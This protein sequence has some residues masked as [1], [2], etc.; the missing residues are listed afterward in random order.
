MN[1]RQWSSNRQGFLE[2]IADSDK[3]R[4]PTQKLLRL[5]WDSQKDTLSLQIQSSNPAPLLTKANVLKTFSKV[6]DPNGFFN[7]F[8]IRF[9]LLFQIIWLQMYDRDES[10]QDKS[11]LGQWQKLCEELNIVAAREIP[12]FIG[13]PTDGLYTQLLC[14]TDASSYAYGVAI[15]IRFLD[16]GN[17]TT[18]ILFSKVKV[19]PKSITPRSNKSRDSISIPRLELLAILIGVRAISFVEKQ[20]HLPLSKTILWSDS[21]I[22]L[23]WIN[24]SKLLKAFVRNRVQ[25]IKEKTPHVEFRYINT[26]DNPADKLTRGEEA[27]SIINDR[28]WWNGP[29]WLQDSQES[30]PTRNFPSFSTETEEAIKKEIVTKPLIQ[31]QATDT[32]ESSPYGDGLQAT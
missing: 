10:I 29:V 24:S 21:I 27:K 6:F 17:W 7:L 1:L 32:C 26:K 2:H 5:Q 31:F 11:L 22:A 12:R 28:A 18:N 8:I 30:W 16:R 13:S 25:E 19:K 20:L 14:F 3:A 4:E 15:Y 23:S 9:K